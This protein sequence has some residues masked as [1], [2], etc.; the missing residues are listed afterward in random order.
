M[1]VKEVD[2]TFLDV[3][4][5]PHSNEHLQYWLPHWRIIQI[6]RLT[7]DNGIVGYGETV[8]N[9]TWAQVPEGIECRIVNRPAAELMWDDSLGAGVQMALFDAV[10]KSLGV[11][12]YRLLGTK[13]RDWCPISWWH[14]DMPAEDWA[15]E[16]RQAV[17]AGYMSAKLKARPWFDLHASVRAVQDVVPDGFH[18]DFDYNGTLGNSA[19]AVPHLKELEAYSEIA[20]VETPIPQNDVAGNRQIRTRF[21][22]PLAMH[23]G[24]PPAITALKED[25]TDGFVL[26]AGASGLLRQG[27]VCDE[28]NKPFWLQLVGTGI[29]TA[30]AAHLGA[31]LAQASWPAI[32]C[33]NIWEHGLIDAPHDVRGGFYKVP[34]APGLG[35]NVD[36]TAFTRY[37]VSHAWV[38]P[39]RHLYRYA[40]ANGEITDYACNRQDL[41]RIYVADAQPISEPGSKL[42][43][44][45]DDGSDG[46]DS[47]Y[48]AASRSPVRESA[49]H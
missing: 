41:H 8:H 24:S 32:T 38:D 36:A 42:V 37:A 33:M 2:I 10:G 21:N 35:I 1:Q 45:P 27:A 48:K 11:P 49:L 14:M 25:V 39:P 7:M 19:N 9:Y 47:R 30:W 40:R 44:V 20:M 26:C 16:C 23:Y 46:F 6:C 31:V 15:E 18:L 17:N 4:F 3:P 34:E 29:T 12:V 5:T 13:I 22:R 43:I 28:A